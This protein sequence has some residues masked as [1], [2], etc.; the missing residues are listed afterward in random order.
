M[1]EPENFVYC[2]KDVERIAKEVVEEAMGLELSMYEV[3]RIAAHIVA[4]AKFQNLKPGTPKTEHTP[5]VW[6]T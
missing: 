5:L 4:L 1:E 6:N 3:E 2:K